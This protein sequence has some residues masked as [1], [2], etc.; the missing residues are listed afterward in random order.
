MITRNTMIVK[1]SMYSSQ[2]NC[3]FIL[4]EQLYVLVEGVGAELTKS[5]IFGTI[6]L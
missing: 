1:P 6:T 3:I 5:P 4:V 2:G